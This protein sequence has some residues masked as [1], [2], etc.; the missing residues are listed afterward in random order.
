VL[1]F[2]LDEHMDHAIAHGLRR[3]GIDV[4]TTTE[5]GLLEAIDPVHVAFALRERRVIVTNDPDF[6]AM[7]GAGIE[8]AGIA[9]APH[10]ERFIGR[11]VTHLCLMSDCLEPAEMV[12]KIEFL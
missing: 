7:A 8:H 2:H 4:T 6:L 5:A 10:G 9:F 11:I 1:A 3:R 12:G